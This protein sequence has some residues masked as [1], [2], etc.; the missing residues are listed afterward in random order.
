M[1]YITIF[2]NPL[3]YV[4]KPIKGDAAV[5]ILGVHTLRVR[6]PL[7]LPLATGLAFHVAIRTT[8]GLM[9]GRLLK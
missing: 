6:V 7:Y 2:S 1:S 8:L 3:L 9:R 5:L 4:T